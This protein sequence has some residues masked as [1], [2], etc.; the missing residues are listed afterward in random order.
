M[1]LGLT[2]LLNC[3]FHH[4]AVRKELARNKITIRYTGLWQEKGILTGFTFP[5]A[6][7]GI[8][9]AVSVWCANAIIV[10]QT[11]GLA[12]MAIFTAAYT[13]RSLIL[14]VPG[15]VNRVASPIF[16]NLVGER[17]TSNYSRLFWFNTAVSA[18]AAIVIAGFL[19]AAAPQLLI[20][21]GKEFLNGGAVVLVV[22]V[23]SVVEVIAN[24][25][26]QPLY[27]HGKIWWQFRTIICWSVILIGV[28]FTT[29]EASGALGLAY[30]YL[31]AHV[32]SAAMYI[33]VAVQ[34]GRSGS[35]R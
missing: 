16:C 29:A 8:I 32:V 1:A 19:V 17:D 21:F 26:Y 28:T 15:L 35:A 5:A 20:L 13:V 33:L 22:A 18:L 7:S 25:L 10:R 3:V 34:I 12:Q 23:M 4:L 9:G 14:F 11:D 31:A 30:A 24:A 6:M 2:A 27:A